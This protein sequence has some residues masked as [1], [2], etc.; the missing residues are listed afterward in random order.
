MAKSTSLLSRMLPGVRLE[1]SLSPE[2]ARAMPTQPIPSANQLRGNYRTLTY[3]FL[4][5]AG[6]EESVVY[7][8]DIPWA[9]VK[10]MLQTAGPV[11]VSTSQ[12]FT[13]V[14]SGKGITLTTNQEVE[15]VIAKGNRLYI[16]SP[17]L[18]RVRVIIEPVPWLEQLLGALLQGF[19]GVA[20][21]VGALASA[22]A[23]R[24]KR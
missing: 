23:G 5:V 14:F 3:T 13:P 6:G 8:A 15:I 18:S 1:T 22:I 10:L 9:K 21:R 2:Q 20:A 19:D 16:A 7:T 17:T 4:T 24:S 12:N 11:G